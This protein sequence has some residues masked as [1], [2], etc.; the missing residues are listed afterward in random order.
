MKIPAYGGFSLYQYS[1]PDRLPQQISVGIILL[2]ALLLDKI[3]NLRR[4]KYI[5][6]RRREQ[7]NALPVSNGNTRIDPM[8]PGFI[9]IARAYFT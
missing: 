8:I 2:R 6:P 9:Q 7:L 3:R 1:S 4:L 5:P